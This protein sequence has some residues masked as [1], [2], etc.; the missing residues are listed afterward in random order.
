MNEADAIDRWLP[1]LLR[2]HLAFLVNEY[3][4]A[5]AP[6]E[7][8]EGEVCVRYRKGDLSV[9][10]RWNYFEGILA[11]SL[12]V[13]SADPEKPDIDLLLNLVLEAR[14]RRDLWI[15]QD[16]VGTTV[17]RAHAAHLLTHVARSLQDHAADV[18]GGDYSIVPLVRDLLRDVPGDPRFDW[19][20]SADQQVTGND[21]R[22]R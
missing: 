7:C 8:F 5:A 1:D 13:A 14:G 6:I 17:T 9:D 3:G 4:F 18:L 11:T 20:V 22:E 16:V 12:V 21:I 15:T 10:V 2:G 19:W